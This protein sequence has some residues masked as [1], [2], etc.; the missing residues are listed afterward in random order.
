MSL[1]TLPV[2]CSL[3]QVVGL[4]QALFAK[5]AWFIEEFLQELERAGAL[6]SD[7]RNCIKVVPESYGRAFRDE[8][9]FL[10]GFYAR[11][12]SAFPREEYL[13]SFGRCYAAEDVYPL[14]RNA[15]SLPASVW[16]MPA[17]HSPRCAIGVVGLQHG[18]RRWRD[19]TSAATPHLKMVQV[20]RG[21][22]ELD[23]RS[24]L[25]DP[26]TACIMTMSRAI[27]I[28]TD[29]SHPRHADACAFVDARMTRIAEL[30]AKME[31][32]LRQLAITPSWRSRC[33][34]EDSEPDYAALADT[35]ARQARHAAAVHS[36]AQALRPQQQ[37][38]P[39]PS[40]ADSGYIPG[41][42]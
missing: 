10:D 4:Y 30:T 37:P 17:E 19:D 14:I 9:H 3:D 34:R 23:C 11:D 6:P 28:T 2:N 15:S 16:N 38:V 20:Q 26:A 41:S 22:I 5:D 27:D 40:L 25:L 18:Q 36:V 1:V 8:K 32:G 7:W 12:K 39:L 13:R 29:R 24:F 31:E 21:D 33:G 35:V 42:S